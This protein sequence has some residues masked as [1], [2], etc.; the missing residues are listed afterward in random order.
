MTG[1]R[2]SL[3]SQK[4][5]PGPE[6]GKQACVQQLGLQMPLLSESMLLC[7]KKMHAKI[8]VFVAVMFDIGCTL[9][10]SRSAQ[11]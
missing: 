10:S 5:Q 3:K 8:C 7:A 9:F 2:V 4:S 6:E 1:S 11:V